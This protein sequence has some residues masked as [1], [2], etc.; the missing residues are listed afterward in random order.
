MQAICE[1]SASEYCWLVTAGKETLTYCVYS[2]YRQGNSVLPYIFGHSGSRTYSVDKRITIHMVNKHLQ[3]WFALSDTRA[4]L[5][6][7]PPINH[8]VHTSIFCDWNMEKSK[9]YCWHWNEYGWNYLVH[10]CLWF[11]Q[12]VTW[13]SLEQY[14]FLRQRMHTCKPSRKTKHHMHQPSNQL[15]LTS[16]E[17][18]PPPV[19]LGWWW[20][21]LR[22]GSQRISARPNA[23]NPATQRSGF[24]G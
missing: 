12:S 9:D 7:A 15:L 18:Q 2:V 20:A 8:Y 3:L 23:F 10:S 6:L 17:L 21:Y 19:V 1:Q 14:H 13:H 16:T 4:E 5:R 22:P 11:F 24:Y